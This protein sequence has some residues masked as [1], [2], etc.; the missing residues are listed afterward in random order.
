VAPV[1]A[2]T[3]LQPLISALPGS[4][5]CTPLYCVRL[6]IPAGCQPD[7]RAARQAI[8]DLTRHKIGG[9]YRGSP[10][11][12][13]VLTDAELERCDR[14]AQPGLASL[15]A[16]KRHLRVGLKVIEGCINEAPNSDDHSLLLCDGDLNIY[17]F[18]SICE[19]HFVEACAW[20]E[21][22][23]VLAAA[24]FT[25]CAYTPG[26]AARDDLQISPRPH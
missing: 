10:L 14:A 19:T 2:A 12:S 4:P 20:L 5:R 3:V 23:G 16:L 11:T 18:A 9:W 22:L 15:R 7:W 1:H 8:N 21:P 6:A 24:G 25:D 13:K 26:F 17:V